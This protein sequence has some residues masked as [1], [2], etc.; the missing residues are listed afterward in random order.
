MTFLLLNG[1]LLWVCANVLE[2]R[3]VSVHRLRLDSLDCH[4]PRFRAVF[5][6]VKQSLYIILF[7]LNNLKRLKVDRLNFMSN[8]CVFLCGSISNR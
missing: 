5:H 1:V 8:K 7:Y 3:T 4:F 6:E 2:E